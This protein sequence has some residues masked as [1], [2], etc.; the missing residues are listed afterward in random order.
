MTQ[1]LHN[2]LDIFL[3]LKNGRTSLSVRCIS[4]ILSL[5]FVLFKIDQSSTKRGNVWFF[6]T[7]IAICIIHA[8]LLCLIYLNYLNLAINKFNV[9]IHVVPILLKVS[10]ATKKIYCVTVSS[11]DKRDLYASDIDS[12][13]IRF[14]RLVIVNNF[15]YLSV[16][17]KIRNEFFFRRLIFTPIKS[18]K[19]VL[20]S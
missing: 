8:R 13:V 15:S 17:V 18:L 7:K 11:L 16:N 2:C 4:K 14:L 6:N 9:S 10:N 20:V 5:L 3:I 1:A 19:V 12:H